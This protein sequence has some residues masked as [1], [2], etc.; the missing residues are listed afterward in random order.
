MLFVKQLAYCSQNEVL[1]M[2]EIFRML[3]ASVKMFQN[4][5]IQHFG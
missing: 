2:S 1:S 3:K 5:L 4:V